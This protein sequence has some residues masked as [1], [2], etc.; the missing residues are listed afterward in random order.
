MLKSYPYISLI[1]QLFM[2]LVL[3]EH[4]DLSVIQMQI[5]YLSF[6][7]WPWVPA[8]KIIP[9]DIKDFRQGQ[10]VRKQIW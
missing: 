3:F 10:C 6:Q 5:L 1:F 4:N 7:S 8:K 2:T 9:C